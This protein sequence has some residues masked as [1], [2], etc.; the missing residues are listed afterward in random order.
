V[1]RSLIAGSVAGAALSVVTLASVSL[2][3]PP[4]GAGAPGEPAENAAETAAPEVVSPV[5][6]AA[7]E[8]AEAEDAA[9]P[10]AGQA[11]PD[12]AD[13]QS[14]AAPETE[15]IEVPEG[16]EFAK[17]KSDGQAE[18]PG[19]EPA[20]ATAAAPAAVAP[21][22]EPAPDLAGKAPAAVP[23]S[24]TE[25]PG[26]TAPEEPAEPAPAATAPA[27]DAAPAVAEPAPALAG[28]AAAPE[29]EAAEA[30]VAADLPPEAP[31]SAPAAPAEPE[32]QPLAAAPTAVPAAEAPASK[33]A[34]ITLAGDPL[35]QPA[36]PEAVTG[37]APVAEPEP[38]AA[39]AP[40]PA[41]TAAEPAV[42]EPVPE[43]V[44]T[45]EPETA[46]PAPGPEPVA[47]AAEPAVTGPAPE[48]A[49]T[50]EP[51]A[52]EPAP[53]ADESETT[54][55]PQ[56]VPEPEAPP[57]DLPAPDEGTGEPRIITLDEPAAE[58]APQI[59]LSREVP[60]V[61][62]NRLPTIGGAVVPDSAAPEPPAPEPA[63]GPL[64]ANAAVFANPEGKPVLAVV[65]IDRGVAGGGLDAS[66]LASLPFPATIALDP[67]REDAAAAAESYRAAGSEVA[68]LAGDLP[69]GATPADFEVT[70]QSYV[71]ALPQAVALIGEP[72][73]AF[74]RSSLSAQH[75]AALLAAD[76]RGFI[77][78]EQGLNAGR[79]AA[80]RAGVPHASVGRLFGAREDNTGTL[81]R[82]LDR[83]AFAAGQNGRMVIALPSSPEAVTA[84]L[85]WAAGPSATGVAI[86][87]V[88]AVML[89]PAALPGPPPEPP[90]EEPAAEA[91]QPKGSGGAGEASDGY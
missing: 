89:A 38:E 78:Y 20:P 63:A 60:G 5:E 86:G 69:E 28:G 30:P 90:P 49:V 10:D 19:S 88:S 33:E 4:V 23:E 13:M 66:A 58:T 36:P 83:A 14:A 52:A 39:P 12:P 79:R 80:E 44:V 50:A 77:T 71:T 55:L 3:L 34:E 15:M 9:A 47:P 75:V 57:G 1:S 43:A 25:A 67:M 53:A 18:L 29:P 59:G 21:A 40:E 87:P 24:P 72:D 82:E 54:T 65:L 74:Q 32:T 46:E 70:Y 91:P 51:E 11:E 6:P 27:A 81:V 76:G 62:V 84:L 16:S 73:A 48:P 68:I 22:A 85:A 35:A 17:P 61:K 37:P 31:E 7:P 8:T 64:A 45:T 42:T 26:L 56:I 41:E 2:M